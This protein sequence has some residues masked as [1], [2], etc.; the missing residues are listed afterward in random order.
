MPNNMANLTPEQTAMLQERMRLAREAR[1]HQMQMQ[2]RQ[3]FMPNG[4]GIPNPQNGFVNGQFQGMNQN[5]G[6]E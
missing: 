5:F 4:V 6:Q 1:M 2:Q 3:I